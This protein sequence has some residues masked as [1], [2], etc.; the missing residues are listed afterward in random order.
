MGDADRPVT[1]AGVRKAAGRLA[2]VAVETPLIESPILN[3]RVGGRVLLKAESLQHYG[4]FKLRGAYNL[5]ASLTPEERE[6][7][8]L[9]WSSGNHAQGVAYA[10]RLLGCP[11]TIVMPADA[12]A[13]KAE[14]VRDLGAEIIAYDRYSEDREA[15]GRRVAEE[16]GLA[17]APSY[18]HPDVIEGQGTAALEAWAQAGERGA[19]FDAFV[20]CCGGG[21]LAAGCATIL[22]EV[23]PETQILIAEPEGYDDA[24]VS[25][26]KGERVFADTSRPTICDAIATPGLGALTFPILKRRAACGASIAEAEVAE[27]MRFA[28]RHLKLVVEPGGA[29]ALAAVL[30]GKVDARGRTLGVTISGGNVDLEQ[31]VAILSK[32]ESNRA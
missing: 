26:K 6:K 14:N 21:G 8:V 2:G 27:A 15:I 31:F 12:P 20:I 16:R 19:C 32:P 28:F 23:S 29:V 24:I 1:A 5:L 17:L 4:S 30:S 22:E 9:A 7:G 13:V 3:D 18:D 11:A 10:A 25:L